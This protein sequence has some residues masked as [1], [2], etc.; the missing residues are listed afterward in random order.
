[1]SRVG[2]YAWREWWVLVRMIGFVSTFGYNLFLSNLHTAIRSHFK[3]SQVD[4]L[5]SSTTNSEL[6]HSPDNYFTS[7]HFTSLHSPH[8]KWLHFEHN[9]TG[10]SRSVFLG[11]TN[12]SGA[13]DQIFIAVRQLRVWWCGA[14]SLTRG[15]VC[16][17]QLLLAVPSSVILGSEFRGTRDHILLSQIRDFPFR[18]FLRLAGLRWRNSTPCSTRDVWMTQSQSYVTTDGQS[19]SLSWYETP[20]WGA[21]SDKRTGLSFIYA[22]GTPWCSLSWVRVPL[23]CYIAVARTTHKKL[24]PLLLRRLPT[25]CIATVAARTAWKRVSFFF[26]CYYSVAGCLSS[27]CQAMLWAN[28]LQ[29]KHIHWIFYG[30]SFEVLQLV[31]YT[32]TWSPNW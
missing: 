16:R 22:T 11:I 25:Q 2:W 10:S 32:R 18:H 19:A 6:C 24:L 7:L 8:L 28:Q 27:R 29:Y 20:M 4:E 9:W 30:I 14:V 5:S 17:L 21:L 12:P 26:C 23:D 31:L 3:S 13:C 1:L 15:R